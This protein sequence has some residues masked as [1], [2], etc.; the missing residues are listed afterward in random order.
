[1]NDWLQI[2]RGIS[3]FT[4][5]LGKWIG[6][7]HCLLSIGV[8]RLVGLSRVGLAGPG[9]VAVSWPGRAARVGGTLRAQLLHL[10]LH[11][12]VMFHER[13]IHQELNS[14]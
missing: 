14:K 11:P 1:M 4:S 8:M 10:V 13:M 12:A 7:F 2:E 9:T 6:P 3:L 5:R